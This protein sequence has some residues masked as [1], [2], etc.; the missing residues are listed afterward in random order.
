MEIGA[1]LFVRTE[2][3]DEIGVVHAPWP[4]LP[5]DVVATQTDIFVITATLPVRADAPCVP[6][7]ANVFLW[8]DETTRGD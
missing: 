5:D 7:L 8:P 1:R 2:T 3:L 4:V 6:V